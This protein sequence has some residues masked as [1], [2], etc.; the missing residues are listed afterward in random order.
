MK[1]NSIIEKMNFSYRLNEETIGKGIVKPS[2]FP[3]IQGDIVEFCCSKNI[4]VSTLEMLQSNLICSE[5][6][7]N[8]PRRYEGLNDS[9]KKYTSMLATKIASLKNQQ[10]VVEKVPEFEEIYDEDYIGIVDE[11]EPY[12][13]TR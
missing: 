5:H 12:V 1:F 8:D 9:M 3:A 2:L 6:V 11:D 13:R 10:T 4:N 7:F